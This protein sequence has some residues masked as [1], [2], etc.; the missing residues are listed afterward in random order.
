MK[1]IL[2]KALAG[3]S[4][5]FLVMGIGLLA[6][7]LFFAN[8]AET[9]GGIPAQ[10]ELKTASGQAVEGREVTLETKRRRGIDSKEVFYEIDLKEQSGKIIQLRLDKTI[11]KN[12]V[13]AMLDGTLTV[14]YDDSDNNLTYD[15]KKDNQ[16][17]IAYADLA[18]M[19][20][21]K[22]NK[23]AAF[24]SSSDMYVSSAWWIGIGVAGLA[25]R[26][27]LTRKKASEVVS[28]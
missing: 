10:N 3:I 13:E 12:Q 19:A 22:A 28:S 2:M 25:L 18:K 14:Q 7:A 9:G 4:Y 17:L 27:R 15:V 24:F 20:Q 5:L 16:S 26:R 11:P 1:N 8:K 21:E 6:S 23:Q